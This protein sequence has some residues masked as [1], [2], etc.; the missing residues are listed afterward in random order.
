MHARLLAYGIL[1]PVLATAL[2]YRCRGGFFGLG[3]L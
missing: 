2:G 3:E 1:L